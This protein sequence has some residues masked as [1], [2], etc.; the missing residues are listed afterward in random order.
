[1]LAGIDS[2]LADLDDETLRRELLRAAR[3]VLG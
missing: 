2:A 3:R 1:M